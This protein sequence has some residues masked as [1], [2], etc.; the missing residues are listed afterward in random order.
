MEEERQRKKKENLFIKQI[1]NTEA[2][3]ILGE[4]TSSDPDFLICKMETR[5]LTL[6]L[7]HR[8]YSINE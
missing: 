5:A 7:S 3:S 2:R 8:S 1:L 6:C 4:L